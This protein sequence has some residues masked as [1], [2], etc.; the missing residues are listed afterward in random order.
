MEG[1]HTMIDGERYFGSIVHVEW[2]ENIVQNI[3]C[4]LDC[5]VMGRHDQINNN[6]NHLNK[7]EDPLD[8]F[9]DLV[10][11]TNNPVDSTNEIIFDKY[12]E[13]FLII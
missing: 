7:I 13:T 6:L 2:L 3:M 12:D 9:D 11:P 5:A 1:W 10:G 8:P 4:N